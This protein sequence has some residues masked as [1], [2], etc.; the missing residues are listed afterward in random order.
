MKEQI[1]LTKKETLYSSM[2]NSLLAQFKQKYSLKALN[3][4]LSENY[5]GAQ[6]ILLVDLPGDFIYEPDLEYLMGHIKLKLG[7]FEES[8]NYFCRALVDEDITPFA[9]DSRGLVF[10]LEKKFYEQS[11]R[12]FKDAC[13]NSQNNFN[14]YNYNFY[15]HLALCYKIIYNLQKNSEKSIVELEEEM[16]EGGG[17]E[18]SKK[19]SESMNSRSSSSSDSDIKSKQKNEKKFKKTHKLDLIKKRSKEAFK[20]ALNIN[21]NSYISL[22]NLGT[23]Y[24]EEGDFDQAGKFYRKAE[25]I[26]S[27][28]NS[29]KEKDWKIYLNLAYLAF[30]E[31]EYPLSMG[32]FETL[33]N[34]FEKKIS[35]KALY[36]FMICLYKNKEWKK[37]ENIA[38]KILKLDP[39]NKRALVYLIIS[40]EKNR[41]NDD[42]LFLLNKMKTK[43][44][45]IKEKYI[46]ETYIKESPNNTKLNPKIINPEEIYN[47]TSLFN[48]KKLKNIIKKK[49]KKVNEELHI[50]KHVVKVGKNNNND[51]DN[52]DL[53]NMERDNL[54]SF[55]F[56]HDFIEKLLNLQSK[57]QNSIELLY[58]IGYIYYKEEEF[59]K[60]EEY[61]KRVVEMNPDYKKNLINEFLGDIYMNKYNSP[62]KALVYYTHAHSVFSDKSIDK[63]IIPNNTPNNNNISVS[64]N[65]IINN[66]NELL[67]VKIGLCYEI[68]EDNDSALRY[69]KLSYE[70]NPEFMNPIFHMGCIYDKMGNLNEAL[71]WLEIAYD[72]E[73]ENV[74]YLQKYGDCLV[75]SDDENNISKGILILEQGIKFFTGNIDIISSLAKGYEKQGRLIEAI[76][77]L[78]KVK[79]YSE[80]FNNKAKIFQLAYYYEQNKELTKAIECFKKVLKLDNKNIEALLHIG[81]IYRSIK[82]NIKAFKCFKQVLILEK[83]NFSA[84][85]GLARLYQSLENHS[86]EAINSYKVCLELNPE[87]IEANLQLGILYLKEK[88]YEDSL[89]CLKKVISLE[90]NNI[91][92]LVSLGNVYLENKNY[93]E[94]I[95]NLELVL[96][97]DKKNVA[98]NAALGDV[99]FS[100]G[101]INQ[102]IE[103]YIY[104]NSLNEKIPEVH[105][106]LGHCFFMYES[107][108]SAIIE[109]VKAIRLVKNTRHDYYY[110]LGN[111]LVASY[112]IKDGIVAYQAAIK[113]NP[114]ILN[115]YYAIAKACYIEKLNNKGIKYLEKLLHLEKEKNSSKNKI[116][117]ESEKDYKYTDVLYLLYN[118]YSALPVPDD[119]KLLNI[120]K[121]LVKNEPKNVEFWEK[122]AYLQEKKGNFFEANKAYKQILVLDPDNFE[123]KKKLNIF[124]MEENKENPENNSKSGSNS[125]NINSKQS[126]SNRRSQSKSQSQSNSNSGSQSNSNSSYSGENDN[127]N[128]NLIKSFNSSKVKTQSDNSNNDD[129]NK[130]KENIDKNNSENKDKN[131]TPES[132]SSKSSKNS[133]KITNKK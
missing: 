115:Y 11:I 93:V 16:Q 62:E 120:I 103:S 125:S 52:T 130:K 12:N 114:H 108:D 116:S 99:F 128:K 75:K 102:A 71:I 2:I 42:L 35:I 98:A 53:E 113:L 123:I 56:R 69:Y 110:F 133:D 87:S 30:Q 37:L 25:S 86:E 9:Y 31:K 63:K 126:N 106:N 95:N 3:L 43:L 127:N 67:L 48:Y 59:I 92:G 112:K 21:P 109:Y 66:T 97:I 49:L 100:M 29:K 94:A 50:Q 60:S 26:N 119:N 5:N 32:H 104:V 131:N 33:L 18:G 88:K 23:F 47:A 41:K 39:K 96:K 80:F 36:V 72:K 38:K 121:A 10:L 124:D 118:L 13:I 129:K 1:T 51:S 70:K 78:E 61:F 89:T 101:N 77:L 28:L 117:Y 79:N 44:K 68:L 4:Y 83:K 73:K 24:A 55:G 85:Y 19:N 45:Y 91:L 57:N 27:Q 20:E 122:L 64:E 111:A 90:P 84:Y 7:E 132:S 65:N 8:K 34:S 74:D 54:Y 17:G 6:M 40:L 82:E 15:N 76:N 14:F 107:F 22:L 105:L 81:Y 46:K 58:N